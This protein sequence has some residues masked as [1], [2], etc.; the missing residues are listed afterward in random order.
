M[1]RNWSGYVCS[2]DATVSTPASHAALAAVLR[3]AAATG[4]TVRAAGAGHSFSPLV[5]TD[6]VILSLDAMQGVIDVDRDRR[7]ARVHAGTRLWALGPALAAHGLAM[8]NLGDINVQSIA[9]ATSTGTHGTGIT[10]GNLA[11]QIDSLTF[12]CADGSEIRAR[13]DTHPDLFAGGRIGLGAL[14]VLTEIGLRLVPAFNLR[15]ERGGMQLDDCL[16]QA[17]ALIAK[18]RSFEFYWFPHTDTV[19]T[20]AWDMTDEPADAVHW[21]SRAS[22]SFLENT[23]FGA[24]CGLGRRV[25]SLCPALSRLCASTVS[26]GR[27]V[28]ASYAMLSTVRRVRFNE[29]EWSVPADRG[30]DA[31]REI[32]AFIARRSFPL[33]FPIE[34]RWVRGDDIWLSPDYGR[35]SVRISAHQYRGMPFDAYFSG[36]QAICRNHGGRPHWG[37]VHAMKAAEL[38]ACYPHWDD[39]LA[40][41]ERM[42]P[43]G[44]F[45]TPYLRTLFGLPQSAGAGAN[46]SATARATPARRGTHPM[47]E[48]AGVAQDRPRSSQEAS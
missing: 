36:V 2:P 26:A 21:A 44:R 11:T 47:H 7:V 9:G 37:K 43:H 4:A 18:H 22:E 35:D 41:R 33:M 29:M 38:A 8:E 24:L 30:A 6:D 1:W 34:Y 23:V 12:M 48:T 10:L 13:A 39:F 25:P 19:L 42:D 27:H 16:A 15:L 28:D 20:K 5:Q 46:A 14:G 40:L 32:R 3:D 17:D 31:L 45:L